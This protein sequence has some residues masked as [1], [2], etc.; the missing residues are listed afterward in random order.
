MSKATKAIKQKAKKS[1]ALTRARKGKRRNPA[2]DSLFDLEFASM[3]LSLIGRILFGTRQPQG[4]QF[5]CPKCD[6]TMSI[7]I[8]EPKDGRVF[9][10]KCRSTM[11][12]LGDEDAVD[13]EFEDVTHPRLPE[14]KGTI[15]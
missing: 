5:R 10:P 4:D 8:G 9:C 6:V 11:V 7:M 15:Q 1:R 2:Y 13:A 12:R 3:G 14:P